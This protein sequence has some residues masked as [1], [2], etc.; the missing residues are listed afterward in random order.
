MSGDKAG[1]LS[2]NVM[3]LTWNRIEADAEDT[4]LRELLEVMQGWS[5][6][7][8]H[9]FGIPE[10]KER[11][12]R[13]AA[14]KESSFDVNLKCRGDWAAGVDTSLDLADPHDLLSQPRSLQHQCQ[15]CQWRSPR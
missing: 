8:Q 4:L 14:A 11:C 5:E 3:D 12:E 13:I 9:R 1:Q 7:R 6:F 2:H 15:I 10:G